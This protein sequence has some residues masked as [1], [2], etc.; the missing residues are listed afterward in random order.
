[1]GDE[2]WFY[3]S[4]EEWIT[5]VERLK[6]TSC[7]HCK[8]VGTLIRHG[9]LSGFDDSN[10]HQQ[11]LRARRIF[12]SNRKHRPGCGRTFSIWLADK[13]RRLSITT[14]TLWTFL[15]LAV[16][17]AIATAIKTINYPRSE[18]TF[19]RIWKRFDRAQSGIRT[20]LLGRGLPPE[21]P[22]A[23]ARRP[24]AAQVLAHLQVIF[25]NTDCPIAA[26]QQATRS[27]FV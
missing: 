14:S 11:T 13:I 24:A 15:Q 18:R 3:R 10:P 2:R 7:P 20:A 23:S 21:L 22:A 8:T 6:Q 25:P 26:F 16:V 27:F 19:Q 5:I 4:D 1:M 12:C 9:S 17:V